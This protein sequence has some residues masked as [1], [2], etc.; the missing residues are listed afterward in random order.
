MQSEWLYENINIRQ[1]SD[2]NL[3]IQPE[4]GPDALAVLETMCFRQDNQIMSEFIEE[5][6]HLDHYKPTHSH[7]KL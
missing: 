4:M 1:F 2:L 7:D 3:L 6:A 5:N